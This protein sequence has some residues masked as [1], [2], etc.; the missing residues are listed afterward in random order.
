MLHSYYFDA[1]HAWRP[2]NSLAHYHGFGDLRQAMPVAQNHHLHAG[3]A[4]SPP[5]QLDQ[6]FRAARSLPVRDRDAFLQAVA[7]GLRGKMIGDG[8]VFRAV[9]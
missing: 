5:D 3:S 9:S 2:H 4:K 6:V 8:E 7:D 1:S